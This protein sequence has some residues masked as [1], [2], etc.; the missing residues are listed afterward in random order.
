MKPPPVIESSLKVWRP[1]QHKHIELFQ[2]TAISTLPTPHVFQEYMLVFMRSGM[3]HVQY[4]NRQA[5]VGVVDGDFY[6]FEPGETWN[7]QPQNFTFHSLCVDPAFLQQIA[8]E[9]LQREKP[10]PHFPSHFLSDPSLGQVVHD[11]AVS[12][13]ASASRLHQEEMLLRLFGE[14]LH[15]HAEDAGAIGFSEGKHPA[16]KQAQEY[17]DAH[18]TEEVALHELACVANLSPF[19][20]S[21]VFRRT[22]GLPPHTYQTQLRLAHAKALLE[23]GYDVG[24]VAM[25]TG[26][27]DQSHFTQQ[28]KRHFLMTPASYRKTAR[29][30]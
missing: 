9:M 8:T 5:H 29:F 12:S 10:L 24:Y 20:L 21:Q 16:V 18:Y 14:V 23:Q 19:H 4:R 13:Q 27:F 17:L 11:V 22:I 2:G 26:F 30:S 15:S 3:T 7:C 6:V 25:E 1:W 28:F